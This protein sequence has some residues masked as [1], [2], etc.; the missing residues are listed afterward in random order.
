MSLRCCWLRDAPQ[1]VCSNCDDI[2]YRSI[3]HITNR[4][5]TTRRERRPDTARLLLIT[6]FDTIS[7]FFTSR[8]SS[9]VLHRAHDNTRSQSGAMTIYHEADI[10][11]EPAVFTSQLDTAWPHLSLVMTCIHTPCLESSHLMRKPEEKVLTQVS[12]DVDGPNTKY[13]NICYPADP[14]QWLVTPSRM[15]SM[16]ICTNIIDNDSGNLAIISTA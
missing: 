13:I 2:V 9:W 6:P 15:G 16:N 4:N 11:L 12:M 7:P 14:V 3:L 1:W 8:V 10:N 5:N